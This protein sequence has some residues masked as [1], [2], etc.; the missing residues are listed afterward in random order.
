MLLTIRVYESV[1]GIRGCR[2]R[3][4]MMAAILVMFSCS[5][6]ATMLNMCR[7]WIPL[8]R[9][10][11]EGSTENGPPSWTASDY[12]LSHSEVWW[13]LQRINVGFC[14]TIA[15]ASSSH[16][17]S[18]CTQRP[19]RN[20]EMLVALEEPSASKVG[21]VHWSCPSTWYVFPL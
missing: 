13:A 9:D 15:Q 11:V 7:H 5:S 18:A 14:H 12:L 6:A 2:P 19:N 3:Q 17:F 21:I 4:V 8:V 20:V 1:Q 16:L 10:L